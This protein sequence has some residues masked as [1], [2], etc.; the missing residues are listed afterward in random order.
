MD[1]N[2]EV[3]TMNSPQCRNECLTRQ[4][5]FYEIT[6]FVESLF[7]HS[8]F[9]FSYAGT[10]LVRIL[11]SPYFHTSNEAH[12]NHG[13]VDVFRFGANIFAVPMSV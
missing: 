9:D 6:I 3:K 7:I 10:F 2:C 13:N 12:G 4:P 1:A 5:L 8:D 11:A